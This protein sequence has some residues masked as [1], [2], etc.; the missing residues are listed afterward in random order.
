[1]SRYR[2]ISIIFSIPK[3]PLVD[4]GFKHAKNVKKPQSHT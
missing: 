3:T 2:P 4:P 1:V